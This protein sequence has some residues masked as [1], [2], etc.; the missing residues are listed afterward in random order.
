MRGSGVIEKVIEC[1][2]SLILLDLNLPD[3]HGK[4]VLKELKMNESTNHIPVVVIS[5]D[6]M[7]DQINIL[8]AA[9]AKNYLTK[10]IEINAFLNAIDECIN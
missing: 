5:A 8:K 2:P 4:E 3:K 1:K 7:P 9:G 10:P 6:A